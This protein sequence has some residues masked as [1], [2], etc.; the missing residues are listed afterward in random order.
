MKLSEQKIRAKEF[1][2]RWANTGDEKSESQKFW[3][4]LLENV[5]GV[6]DP[7][8]YI[9]FETRVKLDNTSFIDGYI[10]KTH[11]LIEQKSSKKALDKAIEQ[12]VPT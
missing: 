8:S 5:L 7:Y 4:D 6:K 10:E 3:L 12:S 11:V 2:Q 9:D 1:S